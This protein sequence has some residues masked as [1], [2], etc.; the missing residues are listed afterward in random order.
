MFDNE[1]DEVTI[2][3]CWMDK[4]KKAMSSNLPC[5]ISCDE[6]NAN[7]AKANKYGAYSVCERKLDFMSFVCMSKPHCSGSSLARPG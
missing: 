3:S 4:K 1:K 2:K 5:E 6:T 7:T